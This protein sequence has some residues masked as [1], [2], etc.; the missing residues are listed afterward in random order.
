M[1]CYT[2]GRAVAARNEQRGVV[3][4]S[5]AGR[6]DR[7]SPEELRRTNQA[8]LSAYGASGDAG[9]RLSLRNT[10]VATNLPL[11]FSIA[12]RLARGTQLPYEDL[13]Q[14]GS[15]G[16]IR[17]VE[18]F[19]P[20]RGVSLSTFAVPFIGGAI[21][22]ELR[23]RQHLLR[24]PRSLWELRQQEAVLQ[25]Q[26]RHRGLVPLADGSLADAL[27]CGADQLR[28]SR[29]LRNVTGMRSL[30]A[31]LAR[32]DGEEPG[33]LIDQLADPASL[34]AADQEESPGAAPESAELAWLRQQLR[35]MDPSQRQLLEG[36]LRLG[37]TWVELG[38]QLGIPPRQAQ[39]RCDATLREVKQAADLW[40]REHGGPQI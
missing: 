17:A 3:S 20:T 18:A 35:V 24:I 14:V 27:G 40:R 38:R 36:R 32:T 1:N 5:N 9:I 4:D 8:L 39:R 10:V 30:D 31:P 2:H 6:P 33:S 12:G 26:R 21:R 7:P 13:V 15:I 25:E 16:L 34:A 22:H 37:C 11:A 28:E 29:G 23:D 19:D